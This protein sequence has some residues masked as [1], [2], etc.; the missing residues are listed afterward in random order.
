MYESSFLFLVLVAAGAGVLLW[1]PPCTAEDAV[2]LRD[3]FQDPPN[4]F[5]PLIITHSG[6]LHNAGTLDWLAARKAGGAV[7]DA[8]VKPGSKDVGDE[9]WNNPTYLNDPEIFDALRKTITEL[10][11]RDQEV[12]LYDELGYPSASAGGR[13]AD[14]HPEY[15]VWAVG[16]RTFRGADGAEVAVDVQH[17]NVEA[18][19][20]LPERDGALDLGAARDL[21]AEARE[22]SFTW[23]APQGAWAV[24]LLERFQ[25]DTWRRHNIPRKNV[26]IMDR[27]AIA[28][29]IEI[30]HDAYA[31]EL[32]DQLKEVRL[33]FTDEPQ[34]GSSEPWMY[35]HKQAT[36]AVQWCNQVPEAFAARKGY[37]L[38]PV[39]PALFHD[40]GPKTAKYRFDFY[41]VQS[42]LVAENY[43]GQ[44]EEWCHAHGMASSGHMLLE[45]SLLFH[46]MFTGSLQKNWS[47]MDL[48]GVDLLGLPPYKTMGGWEAGQVPVAED[49]SCKMASSVT[50]LMGK[51][52]AFTESYAVSRGATLRPVLGVA[53]WQYSGGI[54]HMSTYTIQNQLSAEDYAAFSDFAGRLALLCRRGAPVS[55]VAV[56]VPEGSVWGAYNPPDGGLF[57]HYLKCNP[58]AV[59]IDQV[60][61]DTCHALLERQRDFECFSDDL[62]QQAEIRDGR[63]QLAGQSFPFL[64]MPEVRMLRPD[65][66]A[67]VTAFLD[68]GG[69]VAF[70]GGLPCQSPESGSNP[71]MTRQAEALLA[72]YAERTQH[73]ADL[74]GLHG[75]IDWMNGQVAPILA[76]D[77]TPSVRVLHRREAGQEFVLLANPGKAPASG[78]LAV[79][80]AG[81]V[82]VWDPETGT[83]ETGKAM[84]QGGRIDVAI[85][86]ES[87]RFVVIEAIA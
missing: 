63:L 7:L 16:C 30:T 48:P 29:F 27:D 8:G 38:A 45:E 46:L 79:P 54:T 50:H 77:G 82:S 57:P 87:A 73:V 69:H 25:P 80:A 18:C 84:E 19:Y 12:W 59:R 86:A 1:H 28:R 20:A 5:R 65:T 3:A 60:F 32:G 58:E 23:E 76:W 68:A 26:N 35:G 61:R 70:V 2:S 37:A 53:A 78:A 10:R 17:E 47:H 4:E 52:G 71:E 72:K 49:F 55:D 14:G 85:P 67:K 51:Q 39:L 66:L 36:P 81:T 24:C 9:P 43:F 83:S 15:L 56:L 75:L 22:G 74:E 64:L 41:D 21:T 40:V 13:V 34:F 44:I 33:F 62:L 11:A 31:R 42:D 6:I